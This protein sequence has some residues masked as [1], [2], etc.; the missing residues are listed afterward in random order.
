MIPQE[1]PRPVER[2]SL[3]GHRRALWGTR[4]GAE[5]RGRGT[6]PPP[7]WGIRKFRVSFQFDIKKE[8]KGRPF[9]P[10]LVLFKYEKYF[11][12]YSFESLQAM[13]QGLDVQSLQLSSRGR[14]G[15][16]SAKKGETFGFLPICGSSFLG[17]I[18]S[19]LCPSTGRAYMY[20]PGVKIRWG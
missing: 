18:F 4:D 6:P 10:C 1:D 12:E 13:G 8:G 11:P 3:G 17:R 20:V 5:G 9:G 7:L 19:H 16:L 14:K 15:L 2:H